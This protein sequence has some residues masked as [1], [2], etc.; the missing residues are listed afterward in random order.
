VCERHYFAQE[1]VH[2]FFFFFFFLSCWFPYERYNAG[3]QKPRILKNEWSTDSE[4][5]IYIC[6]YI[7]FEWGFGNCIRQLT[8]LQNIPSTAMV[9]TAAAAAAANKIITSVIHI[10]GCFVICLQL[11]TET[12]LKVACVHTQRRKNP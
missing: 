9:T 4:I 10:F 8:E 11:G 7:K 3:I 5:K 1:E 6:E 2:N 12:E